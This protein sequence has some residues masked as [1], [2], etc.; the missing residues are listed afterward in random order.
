MKSGFKATFGY[1]IA[2]MEDRR[3]QFQEFVLK[4]PDQTRRIVDSMYNVMKIDSDSIWHSHA[5]LYAYYELAAGMHD[6][7]ENSGYVIHC[8]I[9]RGGSLC[10]MAEAVKTKGLDRPV[11][12]IDPFH[13]DWTFRD[14]PNFWEEALTTYF[15]T[16][17][18]F[19]L[20]NK[21]VGRRCHSGSATGTLAPVS[22]V[23]TE[24]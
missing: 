23:T 11:I 6:V 18:V 5:D 19:E 2:D 24:R 17:R 14:N 16:Y 3:N 15:V 1:S 22:G 21:W 12:G 13:L 9:H 4:E 8:G 10:I 7:S 20:I